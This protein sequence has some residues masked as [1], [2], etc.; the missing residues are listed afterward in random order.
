[1]SEQ[2][3]EMRREYMEEMRETMREE[4]KTCR[5][6]AR[7]EAWDSLYFRRFGRLSPGRDEPGRNSSDEDNRAR[8]AAWH[9]TGLAAHDAIMEVVRLSEMLEHEQEEWEDERDTLQAENQHM[10]QII[11][12]LTAGPNPKSCGHDF[13]CICATDEARALLAKEPKA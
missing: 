7:F 8:C 5:H 1:M 10:K 4:W 3:D 6:I 9:D 11:R 12:D 13:T 2:M